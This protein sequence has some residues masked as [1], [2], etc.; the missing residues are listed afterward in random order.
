MS[1][2]NEGE[3]E[4]RRR[5]RRLLNIHEAAGYL[6]ITEKSLRTRCEERQIKYTK[7]GPHTNSPLRFDVAWLE[8]FIAENTVEP[9]P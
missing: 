6:G 2:N 1:Q 9:L 3:S 7:L 8:A 4:H 5:D